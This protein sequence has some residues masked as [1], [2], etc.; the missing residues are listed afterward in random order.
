MVPRL[1]AELAAEL[2]EEAPNELAVGVVERM[3]VAR[4]TEIMDEMDSDVQADV[5]GELC[6]DNAEAILSRMDTEDAANVRRLVKYDDETVGGLMVAEAFTFREMDTT[7]DVLKGSCPTR[8][9]LNGIVDSIPMSV[10][11]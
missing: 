5:I 9:T 1:P 10:I 3:V 11:K 2:T 6:E 7:P 4:A 8:M